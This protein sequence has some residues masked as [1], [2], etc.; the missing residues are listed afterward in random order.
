MAGFGTGSGFFL[1]WNMKPGVSR[2]SLFLRGREIIVKSVDNTH[3]PTTISQ[4][5][6]GSQKHKQ[7]HPHSHSHSH[8]NHNH[9]H[10]H[11]AFTAIK[12]AITARTSRASHPPRPPN[13]LL[14]RPDSSRYRCGGVCILIFLYRITQKGRF[15]RCLRTSRCKWAS[16]R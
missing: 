2:L 6:F 10:N 12:I 11:V 4:L 3:T 8:H 15:V 1:S 16:A 13:K 9:N 5:G 7:S 14:K